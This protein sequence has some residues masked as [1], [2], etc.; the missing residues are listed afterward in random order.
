MIDLLLIETGNGGDLLL[1]GKDL[2][3]VTGYENMPY[4]AMFGGADWWA[5]DLIIDPTQRMQS[6]TEA[7]LLSNALTSAGRVNIIRAIEADLAFLKDEGAKIT[8]TA[9]ITSPD[10]L[11]VLINIDGEE[12]YM[13]WQPSGAF[14]NYKV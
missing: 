5:N 11:E 3:V 14:L 12:I 1:T 6:Q 8:V 9:T 13:N 4:I 2:E 10:R 7:A